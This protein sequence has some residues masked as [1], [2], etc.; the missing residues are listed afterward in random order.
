MT[1]DQLDR[2]PEDLAHDESEASAL[3]PE[4]GVETPG[5]AA[6]VVVPSED[7]MPGTSQEFKKVDGVIAYP[8]S[9]DPKT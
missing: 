5:D 2:R 7:A 1:R 9:A 8:E 6:G 4:K 3:S